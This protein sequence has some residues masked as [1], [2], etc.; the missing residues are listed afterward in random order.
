MLDKVLIQFRGEQM[1]MPPVYSAKI[2]S[3]MRAYELARQGMELP[4]LKQALINIY[5]MEILDFTPPS[6]S[7]AYHAAKG[8]ISG[9]W[10][11]I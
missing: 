2:I 6:F 1:Q 7:C 5:D 11:R 10:P 4:E 3:G 8:P 9:R